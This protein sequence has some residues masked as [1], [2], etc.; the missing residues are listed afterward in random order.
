MGID[1]NVVPAVNDEHNDLKG[2]TG[3][4]PTYGEALHKIGIRCVE[5]LAKREPNELL[6]AL[7]PLREQGLLRSLPKM[8]DVKSWVDQAKIIM[9]V[10]PTYV[11][12]LRKIDI[13]GVEEL[14]KREPNE[15]LEALRP[16]REQGLFES[17]PTID[18]VKG[19]IGQASKR[20]QRTN[21][22]RTPF[23][24]EAEAAKEPQQTPIKNEWQEHA[25]FSVFFE[26]KK[27]ENGGQVWQT[28]VL[29]DDGHKELEGI[30]IA[31]MGKWIL[32]RADLPVE[33]EPIPIEA[34][35][36]APPLPVTPYD[37]QIAILDADVNQ[38]PVA[39]EKRLEAEVRFKTSG[40]K[41]ETLMKKEIPFEILFRTVNRE[42][43]AASL[44]A[45]EQGQL[46]PKEREYSGKQ[47]LPIPVLGRY[48]LEII[49]LLLPPGEEPM[50]F[51]HQGPPFRIVPR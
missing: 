2:I 4:G 15:L 6:E 41:A 13:C 29:D 48:E 47:E 32:E 3:I 44:M 19:W 25:A 28:R 16:L 37:V 45:S 17:P 50:T 51:R 18:D 43:G 27:D 36:A 8:G 10:G 23:E 46:K 38:S 30:N 34:E 22:E 26:H 5:E 1:E 35:A 40:P 9:I 11:E 49:I 33:A 7:R 31:G 21:T 12:A 39:P 14:A 42:S 24:E 20:V